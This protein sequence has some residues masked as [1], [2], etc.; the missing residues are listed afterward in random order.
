MKQLDATTT[1]G[2]NTM[3]ISV[4][5]YATATNHAAGTILDLDPSSVTDNSTCNEQQ[6]SAACIFEGLSVTISNSAAPT[7]TMPNNAT[8][9]GPPPLLR[10]PTNTSIIN[11]LIR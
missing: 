5:P 7:A 3:V 9:A 8:D 11:M 6:Q 4:S 1:T 10:T 2:N